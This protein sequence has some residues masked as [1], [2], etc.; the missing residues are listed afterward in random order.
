MSGMGAQEV[1]N[2]TL[3]MQAEAHD[4]DA[5]ELEEGEVDVMAVGIKGIVAELL[6]RAEEMDD[7]A[8]RRDELER[9]E[10]IKAYLNAVALEQEHGS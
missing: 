8:E 1:C 4:D 6:C 7:A 10:L 5:A 2:G 9:C 3:E